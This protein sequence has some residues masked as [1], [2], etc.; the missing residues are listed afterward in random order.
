MNPPEFYRS[1]SNEYPQE[2]IDEV[3][4]IVD[5]MGVA[6]SE[7]AEL[8]AYQSKG[9][10]HVWYNQWKATWVVDDGPITW[11]DFKTTFLD[12]YFL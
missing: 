8:A 3:F 4:K 2:F 6:S 12:R 11:E 1:K 5:I 7:K 10:A 9:I